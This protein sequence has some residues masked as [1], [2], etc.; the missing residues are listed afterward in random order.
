MDVLPA[1]GELAM[2]ATQV[3]SQIYQMDAIGY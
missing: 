3:G 1:I 2:L